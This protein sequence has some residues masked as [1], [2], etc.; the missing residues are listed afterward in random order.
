MSKSLITAILSLVVSLYTLWLNCNHL[1][2]INEQI[3]CI[4][5][6]MKGI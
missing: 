5:E 4:A 3:T 1:T 6:H 2:T